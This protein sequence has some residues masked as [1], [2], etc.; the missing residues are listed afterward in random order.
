MSPDELLSKSEEDLLVCIGYLV[1]RWNYAESF[2]RQILGKYVRGDSLFHPERL[3]LSKRQSIWIE[4]E[5]RETV[6]PMWQGIGRPY[7]ERLV[8]CYARAREHR[9]HLVHGIY[10]T[11]YAMGPNQAQALLVPAKSKDGKPQAPSFVPH[12]ELRR[13]ASHFHDLAM[14]ARD[15]SI[16]FD[17]LGARAVDRDGN[18]LLAD[19][20]LL[21]APLDPCTYETIDP[22]LFGRPLGDG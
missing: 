3:K 9:N 16:V 15:V 8:E 4:E 11:F 21:I 5:L 19:L 2:A 17:K 20:P 7:L 13:I 1:V 18:P 14:F 12:A 22:D 6:L 10:M